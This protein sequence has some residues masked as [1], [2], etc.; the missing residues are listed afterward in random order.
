MQIIIS[1]VFAI[2]LSVFIYKFYLFKKC[3]V[4]SKIMSIIFLV[5]LLF[6]VGFYLVYTVHY[7]DNQTS[8]MHK[9]YNDAIKI[10]ELTK[11]KP[12]AYWSILCGF[13]FNE[14]N[15]PITQQLSFWYQEESASVINDSRMVIRFNLLLLP[16]SKGNIYLHLVTIVFLSF[17]GLFLIYLSFEKYFLNKEFLL[18]FACFGIPSVMFWTSGIMKEGLLVFFLGI[19]TYQIFQVSKFKPYNFFWIFIAFSGIFFSKFYVALSL[20]PS[21]LF[22]FLGISFSR[23]SHKTHLYITVVL[24]SISAF[25]F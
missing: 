7:S 2:A 20:L 24:M 22:I 16:L 3:R 1:I 19:L 8:D 23:I 9:Y 25:F 10:F 21:L 6:G 4:N 5:K 17:I 14:K 18:L 11:D 12:Q 15:A 13:D